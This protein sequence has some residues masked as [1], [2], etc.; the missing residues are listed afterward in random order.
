MAETKFSQFSPAASLAGNDILVGLQSSINIQATLSQ[1]LTYINA[2]AQISEGQV[3]NLIADLASKLNLTGGTM[4][5]N[6]ILNAD[7]T[8]NLQAATKEYVDNSISGAPYVLKSGDTMTGNLII[9]ADLSVGTT[10]NM[11]PLTIQGIG[12]TNYTNATTAY[13]G[14]VVTAG[15]NN[16]YQIVIDKS[17]TQSFL[18]GINGNP[19]L[20]GCTL[21]PDYI[22][23]S[24][25]TDTG[26][27]GICTGNSTTVGTPGTA[28]FIINGSGQVNI[29]NSLSIGT[30]VISSNAL[31]Q[32]NSNTQGFLPSILTSTQESTLTGLLGSSDAGLQWFN[33]TILTNNY[34]T[35]TALNQ[36]LTVQ[37]IIGGTNVTLDKSVPGKVT[38]NASGGGIPP[39]AA[40]GSFSIQNN[41][42]ATTFAVTST[43]YPIYLGTSISANDASEFTNQ[44]LTISGSSTPVMTYTG[45][46]TQW[47]NVNINLSCRGA[48]PSQSSYNFS[49]FIRLANGTIVSTQYRNTLTLGD[50]I[51]FYD[52]SITGNVQLNTGDSVFVEVQNITGTNSFYASYS[53][54][55]IISIA[56]SV[57]STDGVPQ[58]SSNIYLSQNGGTTYEYLS[59]S[60]TVGNL[61]EFNSTGGQ[62]IDSGVP[63]S[64]L[65]TWKVVTGTTQQMAMNTGYIVKS[66]SPVTFTLPPTS[67]S[68]GAIEIVGA[69]S[70][71]WQ[72]N[73]NSGQYIEYNGITT[74]ISTGSVSSGTANDSARIIYAGDSSGEFNIE[75]SNGMALTLS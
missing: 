68:I 41:T 69:G 65:F 58:G 60:A 27:F 47:F 21:P 56:G 22:Y 57:S 7:P 26:G 2:N 59:G 15:A 19:A 5:G 38:I 39:A 45:T 54:F 50:L 55:S 73:L 31:L 25:Y 16:L 42:V 51:N 52:V 75:L 8:I 12:G 40:Y 72:I 9:N 63:A 35:G 4:T 20:S 49:I 46:D 14:S 33:S 28:N 3:T 67:S 17:G 53:T 61:A 43:F 66:S 37:N 6:L 30:Q 48:S 74:T 36:I 70:A 64:S 10:S 62:L 18:M 1:V 71:T 24:T 29:P 44:F 34:W 13:F 32:L 23:L 11:A